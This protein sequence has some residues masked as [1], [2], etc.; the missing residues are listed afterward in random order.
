MPVPIFLGFFYKRV[1]DLKIDGKHLHSDNEKY[2][3]NFQFQFD[4]ETATLTILEAFLKDAGV[5]SLSATNS[6]GTATT[7]CSVIVK[8]RQPNETSDSDVTN[9]VE[10]ELIKPSVQLPLKDISIFEG[11][12]V[13]LDCVIVGQPEPE[14]IWYHDH[15]PVKESNEIQLL[16]QG[17]R[18]SLIIQEAFIEDA[19]EY[20]VAAINSAGEA[21]SQCRLSITPLNISEPAIRPSSEQQLLVEMPPKFEKLLSDIFVIEND[22]AVLE[23]TVISMPKPDIKWFHNNKEIIYSERIHSSFKDDGTIKLVI[24]NVIPDDKG[25]YTIKATNSSG[26]AK[27]FSNLIVKSNT[28]GTDMPS[29]FEPEE[30]SVCPT[31]KE[32]FADR[33]VAFDDST[34]FECIVV[35]KP[36]PKVK[37]FFNDVPVHGKDFLISTSGD[38]QVLSILNVKHQN[39]GK[40]SC[41]AENEVGK[42]TCVAI[43]SLHPDGAEPMESQ[44]QFTTQEDVSGSSFIT[45]QKHITT[46]TTT[47]HMENGSSSFHST[48]AK[49]DH[50]FKKQDD[51]PAQITESNQF[52]E[53]REVTEQPPQTFQQKLI[54]FTKHENTNKHESI[55]ANSGQISTGKPIRR[56]IAPRFVSPFVG[57]IVDQGTNVILEG[58]IDGYPVPEISIQKNDEKLENSPGKVNI[59]YSLNKIVIE[60]LDVNVKDAGRYSCV[61]S[62]EAGSSTSTADVVV[63]SNKKFLYKVYLHKNIYI[64]TNNFQNQFFHPFLADDCKHKLSKKTIGY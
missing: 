20:K 51:Q 19:G 43:L 25:V 33:S 4:Q 29:T 57:K 60:L 39:I 18:C 5:Y 28:N 54:S 17:D 47:K 23:C 52:E 22:A 38:R 15:R 53:F 49:Y 40:I 2:I 37:W 35:G 6:A 31:F 61:A 48:G 16:F 3:F 7:T 44:E 56:H 8:G 64:I 14:V 10:F 12:G 50:S 63:K 27:C 13:R 24:Q 11:K 46:T 26:D 42:A 41:I 62:N 30:K 9:D 58:I 36:T 59:S 55:I 1:Y 21:F 32:L 34:K 45:M